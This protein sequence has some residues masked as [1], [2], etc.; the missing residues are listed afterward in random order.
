MPKTTKEIAMILYNTKDES[1]SSRN[2]VISNK[3]WYSQE[4]I[5]QLKE[6][7]IHQIELNNIAIQDIISKRCDYHNLDF[8]RVNHYVD[9]QF[10]EDI[11]GIK[12]IFNKFKELK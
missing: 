10:K 7:L 11:A 9:L 6:K 4:E 12:L 2:D 5:E 8:V 3:L 1:I